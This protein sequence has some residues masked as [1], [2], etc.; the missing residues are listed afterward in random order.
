[1]SLIQRSIFQFKLP[2]GRYFSAFVVM[3]FL[4]YCDIILSF[5]LLLYSLCQLCVH[6]TVYLLRWS[7]GNTPTPATMSA[8]RI[9]TVIYLK[10]W[11]KCIF[12]KLLKN[13]IFVK[14]S[15]QYICQTI[16]KK[17]ICQTLPL[18]R[19]LRTESWGMFLR[20]KLVSGFLLT[21]NQMFHQSKSRCQ[22]Q[23][24]GWKWKWSNGFWKKRN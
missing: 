5:L 6:W 22:C 2:A 7:A 3:C 4:F 14:L 24:V 11:N 23:E 9:F 12:V 16:K 13:S 8:A 21:F 19:G 18:S 10:K 17:Y 1:M 15:K 20:G